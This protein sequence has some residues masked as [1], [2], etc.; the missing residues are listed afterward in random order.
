MKSEKEFYQQY[1]SQK[2]KKDKDYLYYC[3][4]PGCTHTKGFKQVVRTGSRNR[5]QALSHLRVVHSIDY[6][7]E[8]IREVVTTIENIEAVT[9]AH[10]DE[11][12]STRQCLQ[13]QLPLL[14]AR[15]KEEEMER[16]YRAELIS[17]MTPVIQRAK[18]LLDDDDELLT[19][20]AGLQVSTTS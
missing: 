9:N 4:V 3:M 17:L 12:N 19:G 1:V 18:E 20:L 15:L 13:Q 5:S 16:D 10:V 7:K 14:L 11:F 6:N 8:Q 2:N